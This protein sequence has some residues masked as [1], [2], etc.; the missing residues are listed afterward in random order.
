MSNMFPDS[1]DIE[2]IKGWTGANPLDTY[3]EIHR[4]STQWNKAKT[5][6]LINGICTIYPFKR[7]LMPATL[8]ATLATHTFE[9]LQVPI[10]QGYDEYLKK[11][12]GDYLKLP[13]IEKRGKWHDGGFFDAD[14][15]YIEYVDH[16]KKEEVQLHKQKIFKQELK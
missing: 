6:F 5:P 15:P 8:F 10:P 9:N 4:I 1:D 14:I 7:K 13:P 12:Y 3:E 2:R 16:Y 11:Q